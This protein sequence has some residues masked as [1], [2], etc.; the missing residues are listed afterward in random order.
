M[1]LD[2]TNPQKLFYVVGFLDGTDF[3]TTDFVGRIVVHLM[4]SEGKLKDCDEK[5]ATSVVGWATKLKD[6]VIDKPS[7]RGPTVDQLVAGID[8]VYADFRN[9]RIPIVDAMEVVMEGI[10]GSSDSEIEKRLEYFR[11]EA[12]K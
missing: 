7:M 2:F 9:R 3:A 5:C 6:D 10:K 1:W 12:S 4:S 8:K 11:K